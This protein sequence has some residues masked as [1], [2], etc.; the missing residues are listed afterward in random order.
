M[1]ITYV[2]GSQNNKYIQIYNP[3]DRP[4]NLGERNYTLRLDQYTKSKKG[5]EIKHS[6]IKELPL[7]GEI[8]AGGVMVFAHDKAMAYSGTVAVRDTKVINFNGDDNIAL[9]KGDE[10]IDAIGTWG[11]AWIKTDNTD[12]GKDL[13]LHRKPGVK[14]PNKTY[15]PDEWEMHEVDHVATLGKR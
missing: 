4:I 2:E 15:T 3:T 9:F 12:A 10:L 7:T 6:G 1:I 11:S 14:K 13:T 8:P 5:S